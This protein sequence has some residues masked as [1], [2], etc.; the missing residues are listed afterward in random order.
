MFNVTNIGP[1]SPPILSLSD[2][3]HVE[4][5]GLLALFQRRVE[6]IVVVDG[7]FYE[8]SCDYASDLLA[9]LELTR[10]KLKCSFTGEWDK[11]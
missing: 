2:G 11:H 9:T 7:G 1:M 4:N 3:G 6:K 8:R 5:L 10:K